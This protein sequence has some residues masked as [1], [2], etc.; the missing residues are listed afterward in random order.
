LL[1]LQRAFAPAHL[2]NLTL[3]RIEGRLHLRDLVFTPEDGRARLR[4]S[5]ARAA[6]INSVA[7]QTGLP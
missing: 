7:A 5:I 3:N 6:G 1:A 2:G 4:R